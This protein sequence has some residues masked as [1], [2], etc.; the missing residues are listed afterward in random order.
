MGCR[1]DGDSDATLGGGE[2]GRQWLPM[3]QWWSPYV[4]IDLDQNRVRRY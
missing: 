2:G 4:T 1:V 3:R